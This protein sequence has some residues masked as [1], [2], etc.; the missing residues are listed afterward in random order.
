MTIRAGDRMSAI[1]TAMPNFFK[2]MDE[3][4]IWRS[5][6][7]FESFS[8]VH[9]AHNKEYPHHDRL[10]IKG[11]PAFPIIYLSH[12]ICFTTCMPKKSTTQTP[13]NKRY[14]TTN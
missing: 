6:K 1:R 9:A 13:H 11:E 14:Q 5:N 12:N 10:R 4:I 8:I 3:P 7:S 2:K